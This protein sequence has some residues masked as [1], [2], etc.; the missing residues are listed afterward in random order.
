KSWIKWAK[1]SGL[2]PFAKLAGTVEKHIS[3][4][5]QWFSSRLTNAL[6]EGTNSL[7]SVIKSRARGFWYAENLISMCYI[8]SAQEKTDM[9]GRG[10]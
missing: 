2:R 6:M 10:V 7:I 1:G 3:H 9:Y 5:L 8:V 4:I